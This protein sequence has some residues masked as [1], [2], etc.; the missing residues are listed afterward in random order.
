[1]FAQDYIYP[2]YFFKYVKEPTRT[3]FGN[4]VF[5]MGGPNIYMKL[6]SDK[7]LNYL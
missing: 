2:D 5:D 7:E 4:D 6:L 1:M 3:N